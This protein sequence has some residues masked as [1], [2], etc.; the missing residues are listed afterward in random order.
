MNGVKVTRLFLEKI[1]HSLDTRTP[2]FVITGSKCLWNK[3]HANGLT[4][5]WDILECCT[6]LGKRLPIV[7]AAV[8][9]LP[10]ILHIVL[11]YAE[12]NIH[13]QALTTSAKT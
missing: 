11:D 4:L 9:V 3:L 5:V 7:Y 8:S 10:E 12:T 2:F 13:I 1:S 6:K